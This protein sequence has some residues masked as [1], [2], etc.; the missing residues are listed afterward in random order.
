MLS[1]FGDV[2]S[3]S[4]SN[5]SV[6]KRS[7]AIATSQDDDRVTRLSK[8]EL[9]NARRSLLLP[10]QF[11]PT[12]LAGLSFFAFWRLF[13]VRAGRL[14]VRQWEA[15]VV[16]TGLGWPSH[17]QRG[18]ALHSHYA[19][20]AL[21]AYM[22]CEGFRGTDYV[23][24]V[25]LLHYNNEW[26]DALRHFISDENNLWCPKWLRRNYET[27]NKHAATKPPLQTSEG[28][29][30]ASKAPPAPLPSNDL[31]IDDNDIA[32]DAEDAAAPAEVEA[33]SSSPRH[34]P[35]RPPWQLHSALGPNLDAEASAISTEPMPEVINSPGHPWDQHST[36]L[37]MRKLPTQWQEL[38][39]LATHP[40]S[41]ASATDLVH[42]D[43]QQLFLQIVLQ[44]TLSVLDDPSTPPLRIL[45]LG[46]AGAGKTYA[47]Q[48]LLRV[49]HS[50]FQTRSLPPETVR[51]AAPTGSAAFNMRWGATTVH[52]LIHYFRPPHFQDLPAASEA[53]HRFQCSM[54][55]TR[56]LVLDEVS[57]IGRQMMGRI[58]RRLR[59]S[60]AGNHNQDDQVLGGLSC[61]CVGDPAQCEAIFDQQIYD[62]Q[63]KPPSA[64]NGHLDSCARLSNV[65]LQ[66]Y[67]SFHAAIVLK[68]PQRVRVLQSDALT[69]EE[70]SYN[71][72]A[73]RF[74]EVLHRLRDLHWTLEDYYW[75][76]NR[77]RSQV[78]LAE[79]LQFK[80]AP[81]LMDFRRT[82]D[83]NPEHNCDFYN[84][85]KLRSM[86]TEA[87]TSVAR[88]ASLHHNIL[89]SEG[90]RLEATVFKGLPAD[91]E[92]AEGAL[93]LITLNLA[94]EHGL[95]NG[96]HG[97]VK[98]IIYSQ[99]KN[100]CCQDPQDC[101]PEVVVL[102]CPQY[103]GPPFFQGSSFRTWIPLLPQ[104][105]SA[106]FDASVTRTVPPHAW[107]GADAVESAR[108]DV[109]KSGRQPG[110]QGS[111]ARRR[112]RGA[113]PS[114]T[115]GRLVVGRH[116]SCHGCHS[117]TTRQPVL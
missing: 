104:T 89:Q 84:R 76:C 116:V 74:V 21:Y 44:H 115:S 112:L 50:E 67:S 51:V 78:T 19:Q 32:T 77:K 11:Q 8:L 110:S 61:V 88:F 18:H 30:P 66:V 107:L 45:L 25:V 97:V 114:A 46:T 65:G 94:V 49:L 63:P 10:R 28:V 12:R 35:C 85:M 6:C 91:L 95:M 3:A 5:W 70:R 92:I 111:F 106:D 40:D 27:K 9:F 38:R 36:F 87:R 14:V 71:A 79:R 23:D 117:P 69:A 113:H 41:F 43:Y 17:A 55:H 39:V 68:T 1:S 48:N 83:S 98:K 64:Q 42:D 73:L 62:M 2:S 58:D 96:T 75:L 103:V 47:V 29:S 31:D 15:V 90:L 52:R 101:M 13:D 7:A 37:D 59:Q 26:S 82:T 33:Q 108:N 105:V 109:A 34:D 72:R 22:P 99:G 53:L 56:L 16:L 4:L 86:A 24:E 80:D 102:D 93:V 54:K 100:P 20:K 60:A 57:M 81:V